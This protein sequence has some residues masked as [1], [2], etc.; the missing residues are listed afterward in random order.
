MAAHFIS[1]NKQFLV[2]IVRERIICFNL[3]TRKE[4]FNRKVTAIKLILKLKSESNYTFLS[5]VIFGHDVPYT[6]RKVDKEEF[7]RICY[8]N[9]LAFGDTAV[10]WQVNLFNPEDHHWTKE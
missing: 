1:I 9:D 8:S 10:F 7:I 5:D 3:I 4:V 2:R 6:F